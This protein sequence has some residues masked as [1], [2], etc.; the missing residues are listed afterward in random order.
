MTE[1][2]SCY[3]PSS[4][5]FR[6][7]P[8]PDDDDD[9]LNSPGRRAQSSST[10]AK[11]EADPA[12]ADAP[13]V[14]CQSDT[15][16]SATEQADET[17]TTTAYGYHVSE[18]QDIH[19]DENDHGDCMSTCSYAS[20]LSDLSEDS[21]QPLFF[22]RADRHR[23]PPCSTV[24]GLYNNNNNRSSCIHNVSFSSMMSDPIDELCSSLYSSRT[25]DL[26][27]DR[28]VECIPQTEAMVS[29]AIINAFSSDNNNNNN[30]NNNDD[31]EKELSVSSFYS[32]EDDD[33][34]CDTSLMLQQAKE[35]ARL[36]LKNNTSDEEE[37]E[38]ALAHL[39]LHMDVVFAQVKDE[40]LAAND[41]ARLLLSIATVLG[42]EF[43]TNNRHNDDDDDD[44]PFTGAEF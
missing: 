28:L 35:W 31:D 42:L 23:Y 10:F 7:V 44:V 16:S 27:R 37:E 18:Q 13:H 14:V 21:E 36:H 24:G 22:F 32:S 40:R 25:L 12:V 17:D 26:L 4:V 43:A 29:R 6:L 38:L 11:N 19:E 20:D 5:F 34:T 9:E 2:W 41:A 33:E 39:Q 15:D 1:E 8:I 30:N 3:D